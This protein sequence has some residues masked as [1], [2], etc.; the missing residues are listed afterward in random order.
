MLEE[1]KLAHIAAAA[2]A[3]HLREAAAPSLAAHAHSAAAAAA[4]ARRHGDEVSVLL[5]D[6]LRDTSAA[7]AEVAKRL[8][9]AAQARREPRRHSQPARFE[10]ERAP[11][12]GYESSALSAAFASPCGNR[13]GSMRPHSPA[14]PSPRARSLRARV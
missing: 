3:A 1:A 8:V 7:M 11:G 12:S 9:V 5:A 13:L 14:L 4:A 10:P 2:L 6:A